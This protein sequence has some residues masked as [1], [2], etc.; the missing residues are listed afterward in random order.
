MAPV[1]SSAGSAT[2]SP[3][4]AIA[5]SR[6]LISPITPSP[7]RVNLPR[8]RSGCRRPV[9][10]IASCS[11]SR[12]C[13]RGAARPDREAEAQVIAA[14]HQKPSEKL[15]WR[16]GRQAW[17]AFHDAKRA[18]APGILHD[19]L[20]REYWRC[21][22]HGGRRRRDRPDFAP[23]LTVKIRFRDHG[24]RRD[25]PPPQPSSRRAAERKV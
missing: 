16:A 9:R 22:G 14:G 21:Q 3:R 11:G 24:A 1:R 6:S 5:P 15:G 17:Q 4:P 7:L 23:G 18:T 20:E 2:C 8:G 10:R 19:K 25:C 12:H 13:A